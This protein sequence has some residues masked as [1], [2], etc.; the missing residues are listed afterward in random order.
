MACKYQAAGYCSFFS[1]TLHEETPE[2]TIEDVQHEHLA[3]TLHCSTWNLMSVH[4][5]GSIGI[6]LIVICIGPEQKK[7]LIKQYCM[8][9]VWNTDEASLFFQMLP[10]RLLTTSGELR[11]AEGRMSSCLL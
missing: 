11:E 3:S 9:D 10:D 6:K 7:Q 8:C 2:L 5:Q 4:S 1:P